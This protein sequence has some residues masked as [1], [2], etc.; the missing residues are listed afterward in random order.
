MKLSNEEYRVGRNL[1]RRSTV[2]RCA[3]F[4]GKTAEDVYHDT[5]LV[6]LEKGFAVG[7][8][9]NRALERL[10]NRCLTVQVGALLNKKAK[11]YSHVNI[12]DC[13]SLGTKDEEPDDSDAKMQLLLGHIDRLISNAKRS[14][15]VVALTHIRN[16][17]TGLPLKKTNAYTRGLI[18]RFKRMLS[19]LV[20]EHE[21]I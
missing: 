15:D 4:A 12:D 7:T 1:A 21:N 6:M 17:L 13:Y 3:V 16:R 14:T 5:L 8:R 19:A 18:R 2:E 11:Y 10:I 9:E 20:S